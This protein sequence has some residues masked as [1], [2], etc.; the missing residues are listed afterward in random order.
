MTDLPLHRVSGVALPVFGGVVDAHD[1]TSR[2]VAYG[3]GD[4]VLATWR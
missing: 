3:D 4:A 1:G 2:I